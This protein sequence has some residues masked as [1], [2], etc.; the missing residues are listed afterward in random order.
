[1]VSLAV[2]ARTL[3]SGRGTAEIVELWVW[4]SRFSVDVPAPV[5]G[6]VAVQL[7]RQYLR[8]LVSPTIS[9]SSAKAAVVTVA[10]SM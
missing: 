9:N 3:P 4:G 7:Y 10:F 2:T 1:V 8:A 5:L 6:L